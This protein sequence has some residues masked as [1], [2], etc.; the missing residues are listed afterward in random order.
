MLHEIRSRGSWEAG[1][2][3]IRGKIF[4]KLQQAL[5]DLMIHESAK[6]DDMHYFYF[7]RKMKNG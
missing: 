3:L 7:G 2:K 1:W 5:P 6:W 4:E